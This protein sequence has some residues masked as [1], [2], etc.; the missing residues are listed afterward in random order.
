M[1]ALRAQRLGADQRFGD[2]AGGDRGAVGLHR[3]AQPSSG[4]QWLV[5]EE[6]LGHEGQEQQL[7][8]RKDDHQ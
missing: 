1:D 7:H 3:Q 4:H 2:G 8:D 6:S 5:V